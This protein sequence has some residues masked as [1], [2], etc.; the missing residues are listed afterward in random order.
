[1]I[2]VIYYKSNGSPSTY[3]QLVQN[4]FLFTKNKE[5]VNSFHLYED[6]P[7]IINVAPLLTKKINWYALWMCLAWSTLVSALPSKS[8]NIASFNQIKKYLKIN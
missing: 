3:M 6:K 8:P 1:M 5:Q 2:S 7:W 4:V